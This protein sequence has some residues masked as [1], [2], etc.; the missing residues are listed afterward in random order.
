VRVIALGVLLFSLY[1]HKKVQTK[2]REHRQSQKE[3][4]F[5][6]SIEPNKGLKPFDILT[7]SVMSVQAWPRPR[8]VRQ[9][10]ASK[11]QFTQINKYSANGFS[12]L[13]PVFTVHKE[14]IAF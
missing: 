13:F 3:L 12:E 11:R 1:M 7:R 6:F 9:Y 5:P 8:S 2:R 4:T 14:S 10:Q